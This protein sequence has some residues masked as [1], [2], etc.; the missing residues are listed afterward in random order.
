MSITIRFSRYRNQN[1]NVMVMAA[2][3]LLA[4]TGMVGLAMDSGHAYAN[5]TRLQNALDASALGAA[6][7]LDTTDNTAQARAAAELIFASHLAQAANNELAPLGASLVTEF[8][9]T[10][11]PFVAGGAPP[12]F[13]RVTPLN[14]L[15]ITSSLTRVF[16]V[17]QLAVNTTAIAGPSPVLG[18]ACDIAPIMVCGNPTPA[19]GTFW[20]YTIGD[21]VDLIRP[22]GTTS[23]V[24]SGNF[25]LLRL[26]GTGA[27]ELRQDVAGRYGNCASVGGTVETE[28][29]L[30]AGPF[31][32]GV[33]TRFGIYAGPLNGLQS[34]YPPDLVTDRPLTYQA[35]RDR[36]AAGN[37]NR[38]TDGVPDR[39]ILAVPIGNCDGTAT[40]ASTLRVLGLGCFF[41][42]APANNPPGPVPMSL[43]GEFVG[44]CNV[45]GTPGRDTNATNGPTKIQ[46]YGNTARWDS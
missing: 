28:P 21:P 27:D 33:N 2:I 29:G 25:R 32:Q 43:P 10:L 26:S 31:E 44:Q 46:L 22:P 40:G 30:N 23:D 17:T 5:K 3:A 19:A 4:I 15:N 39:R 16:G 6:R 14:P 42:R 13:V 45:N 7:V 9:I 8:S 34:Q 38:P 1:G 36:Y 24:G 18:A 11:N 20:G 12:R 41:L 37:Y 35:Y